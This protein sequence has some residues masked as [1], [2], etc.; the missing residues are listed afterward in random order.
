MNLRSGRSVQNSSQS[1]VMRRDSRN[2]EEFEE[3]LK[4]FREQEMIEENIYTEEEDEVTFKMKKINNM[5]MHYTYALQYQEDNRHSLV[6]KV[7]TYMEA[8]KLINNNLP[9]I[10]EHNLI[11]KR[12]AKKLVEG[13]N[14]LID[15]IWRKDKTRSQTKIFDEC[16]HFIYNVIDIV[17]HHILKL[18]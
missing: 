10:I 13:G 7:K 2:Y 18:Y 6:D 1:K 14:K 3:R 11:S 4:Y 17:E 15:D 8:F 9:F 16:R 12:Q 5:L